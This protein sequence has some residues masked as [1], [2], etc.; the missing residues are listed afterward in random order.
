MWM[1]FHT[2]PNTHKHSRTHSLFLFHFV[3]VVVVVAGNA[4]GLRDA[5]RIR[6][7]H[8][9][10]RRGGVSGFDLGKYEHGRQEKL[11]VSCLL[12]ERK[13]RFY[14]FIRFRVAC[15]FTD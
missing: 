8:A 14:Y 5:K 1:A 13:T 2:L 9:I 10:A 12:L 11:D 15:N 7:L 4:P 6:W 3:A